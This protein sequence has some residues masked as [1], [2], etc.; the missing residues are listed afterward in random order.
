MGAPSAA[1]ADLDVL[2][3]RVRSGRKYARVSPGLVRRIGAAELARLGD[4]RA[5][6]RATQRRL[7]QVAGAYPRG[8]IRYDDWL[9][10]LQEARRAGEKPFRAACREMMR[11][12][13]STRERL[14]ILDEFYARCLAPLET[15]G[16]VAD[17]ACGL[18]PLSV[19]WMPLEPGAR[20]HAVDVYEDLA[21][22][23]GAFL[24]LVGLQGRAE[25]LDVLTWAPEATYDVA[26]MLKFVPCAEQLVTSSSVLGLLEAFPARHLL[27]SFPVRSLGGGER[28]M[29]ETYEAR[30]RELVAGQPW[31]LE[32]FSFAT[33]LA[34]LVAKG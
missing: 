34:F 17:V 33:E 32:R 4:V 16:A 12:H 21:A 6:T 11:L 23:L 18:G 28:G 31:A 8:R 29:R 5:A 27:V 13:A 24:P 2:V 10:R 1:D 22:F 20:Y 30:F 26:L 15:L 14:P 9:R 25:A 19:P 3:A 7:H